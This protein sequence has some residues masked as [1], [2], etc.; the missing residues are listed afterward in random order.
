MAAALLR[1]YIFTEDAREQAAFYAAA[2]QGEIV[3]VK[4]FGEMPGAAESMKDRVMHLQLQ[5]AGQLFYLADA[6]SVE[7]GNGIDLT[8][9]FGSDE[10]TARAFEALSEGGSVKMPLARMFWGTLF[11]RVEDRFGVS[12]QLATQQQS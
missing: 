1:P 6:E 10:E 2:L 12:W 11:G 4:T 3:D 7:R 8:L 9:E 5:A